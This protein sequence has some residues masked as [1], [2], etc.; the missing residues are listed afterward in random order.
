MRIEQIDLSLVKLNFE[1]IQPDL[2]DFNA[3][4]IGCLIGDELVGI[5]AWVEL[6]NHIYLC[7][8]HVKEQYRDRG[9]YK[10]LNGA[11]QHHLK[12]KSKQQI[13]YCNS[14]SLKTFLDYGFRIEKNLFKVIKYP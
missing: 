14:S 8:D 3:K 6:D 9:I 5:V 11:R 1:Q 12:D 7:H 4:Y 13:A 2:V 10:L